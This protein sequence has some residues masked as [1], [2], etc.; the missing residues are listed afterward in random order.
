MAED[1]S[2][3]PAWPVELRHDALGWEQIPY[4]I[5]LVNAYKARMEALVDWTE[6]DTECTL[7]RDNTSPC[8]CGLDALL[9]ACDRGES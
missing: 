3:L 4:W 8:S 5:T 2:K 9:A 7:W 1:V 6:H